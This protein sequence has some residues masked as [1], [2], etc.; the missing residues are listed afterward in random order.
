MTIDWATPAAL[1]GLLLLALP[2]AVHLFA[3]MPV[4]RVVVPS[5]RPLA[6]GRLR[7]RRRR[8][9]RH[10][11]LLLVRLAI[12]ASAV[13]AAAGPLVTT[14]GRRA[15]WA[16]RTARAVVIDRGLP[17]SAQAALNPA[18]AEERAGAAVV[19]ERFD[20]DPVD[21]SLPRAL[22]WLARQ[23]PARRELVV[24][25]DASSAPGAAALALVPPDTGIRVRAVEAVDAEPRLWVG[26]DADGSVVAR[27]VGMTAAAGGSVA[28]VAAPLPPLPVSVG[29]SV[30]DRDRLD[31]IWA[32]VVADGAFL[33]EPASWRRIELLW[34]T[35]R[36]TSSLGTTPLEAA[37]RALLWPLAG[38]L[39]HGEVLRAEAAPWTGVAPD[40]TAARRGDAIV[41]RVARPVDVHHAAAV[42]RAALD[43]A[44]GERALPRAARRLTRDQ[45][46]GVERPPGDVPADAARFATERDGR[47]LWAAAVGLLVVEMA[48]RRRRRAAVPPPAANAVEVTP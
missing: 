46:A 37:D 3:R 6:G 13:A 16:N 12:V 24:I 25:G 23:G 27:R 22:A 2:I 18:I 8:H 44:A 10:P 43:V 42:L 15:A 30:E 20:A 35:T 41:I 31:A 17:A 33:R 5:L 21:A 32:G 14:P 47:W 1:A 4:R 48:V 29:G 7:L 39:G 28:V 19:T 9:L 36:T 40:L 11:G 38:A 26:A 45:R 34:T